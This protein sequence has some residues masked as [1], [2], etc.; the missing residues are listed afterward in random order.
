MQALNTKTNHVEVAD[1][2]LYIY[3]SIWEK[4]WHVDKRVYFTWG[5][6]V[7]WMYTNI[8]STIWINP[9]IYLSPAKQPTKLIP[10][11]SSPLKVIFVS[12]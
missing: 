1:D 11:L 3:R 4:V 9:C 10:L 8:L 5:G 7:M 2:R 6:H 12:L